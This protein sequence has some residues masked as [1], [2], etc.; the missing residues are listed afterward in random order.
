MNSRQ[1]RKR[2]AERHNQ[3]LVNRKAWLEK[4]ALEPRRKRGHNSKMAMIMAF[5]LANN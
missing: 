4:R 5:A 1:R 3:E 2:E